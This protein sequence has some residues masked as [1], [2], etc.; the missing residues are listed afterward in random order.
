MNGMTEFSANIIKCLERWS[1]AASKCEGNS[2]CLEE[3][4]QH[5]RS[6]LDD[7]FPPSK[8]I[9]FESDKINYLLSSVFFLANRLAKSTIGL[10][11]LDKAIGN[12]EKVGKI[13][14]D[15]K[16][17]TDLYNKFLERLDE[18]LKKYF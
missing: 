9:E 4:T 18:I 10:S 16:E 12:V 5:L 17:D 7:V 13:S 3:C 6:C 2:D 14:F 8:S 15:K 11:E 1:S